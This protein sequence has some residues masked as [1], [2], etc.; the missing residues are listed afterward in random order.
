MTAG[1]ILAK[2][3]RS[4]LILEQDKKPGGLMQVFRRRSMVFPTGV[5]RLG[6]LCDGEVLHTYFQYLDVYRRLKLI[7]M[8]DQGFEEFCF[9]KMHF[10]VPR[11]YDAFYKSLTDAF[12]HEEES[13]KTY[14]SIMRR[15]VS[16]F[17]LYN[18][19]NTYDASLDGDIPQ[20]SESM[21]SFLLKIGCSKKLL[22]VLTANNP[23][24]GMTPAECPALIHFFV[25]DSF[26]N[27]A[28][29]VNEYATPLAETFTDAFNDAGGSIQCSARVASLCCS[30]GHV[31]GLTL[32]TGEGISARE[33]LFTGHP[34]GML[35][36]TPDS[37]FRPAYR[38]RIKRAENTLAAFGVALEWHG[39]ECPFLLCD[40]YIY[41][42][43]YDTGKYYDTQMLSTL[44]LSGS[45]AAA[46]AASLQ[47]RPEMIYCS[48]LPGGEPDIFAVTALTSVS[49]ED[50]KYLMDLRD[51]DYDTYLS[52]KRE[53]AL[54][55]VECMDKKW[56][57]T[58]DKVRIADIYT[59]ATFAR[60]TLTPQGAAYGI[61]KNVATFWKN[62]LSPVTR[63]KGLYLA[64]QSLMASGIIGALISSV[65][66]CMVMPEMD[67]LY[68]KIQKG[69]G[70]G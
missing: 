52:K 67:D 68:G 61:K 14:L 34:S 27:S 18:F 9:P 8:A 37:A 53:M 51:K 47:W 36:I 58:R 5:H 24:Y 31:N 12:P 40:K 69:S 62:Q 3:G 64:G 70:N 55:V 21:E 4:V 50:A 25:T 29:R 19:N 43:G 6:S 42:S 45:K 54:Q 7:P 22:A 28:W 66:A 16:G 2:S 30:S 56:R 33:V 17:K 49:Y 35:D 60:Y 26:L 15:A 10:K 23:L 39:S 46:P 59:P 44:N 41:G 32:C 1:I 48:A 57:G 65:Q 11:G 38:N 63:V 13:I 20:L